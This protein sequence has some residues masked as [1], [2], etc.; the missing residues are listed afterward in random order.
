MGDAEG[1]SPWFEWL[2][3]ELNCVVVAPD[4][5][6]APETPH[7]GPVTDCYAGLKWLYDQSESLGVDRKRIGVYGGSAGGGLAAAVALLARDRN[8]VPLCFQC[9]LY[10]MLDDRTT[11]RADP[12]PFA[13]EYAW[14]PKDN[15]FGWASLLGH[16]PGRLDVSPYASPARASDL[17]GLPPTFIWVGALDLFV[18]ESIEYARRLVRAGVPTELRVYPGVTHGNAAVPDAPS[19]KLSRLDTIRVLKKALSA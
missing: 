3:T 4:Y 13:G 15:Y 2:A 11:V 17:A 5:R 19:T 1:E 6:L 10:P 14:T 8:E 16:E 9:L 12:N 7:P 18:D